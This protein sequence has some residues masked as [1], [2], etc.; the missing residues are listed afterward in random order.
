MMNMDAKEMLKAEARR[1]GFSHLGI[2]ALDPTPHASSY[3]GWLELGWHASM[4]YLSAPRAV[5]HRLNPQQ[6]FPPARSLIVITAAYPPPSTPNQAE[7]QPG[8][9][10]VA[11]YA[12]GVD[13]HTLLPPQLRRLV[14]WIQNE[15][16]P[17][18]QAAV[19]TDT[20]P[21]LERDYASRAGLG[22]IGKN[23]C[24]INPQAGS[25]LFLAEIFLSTP[26][27]PDDPFDQ[28]LCGT[29]RRCIEACPTGCI[30]EA[31]L[32]DARRCIS[33]LTIEN[34]G[35][36]P[37]ELR[38]LIGS[39]VFG[40]DICQQVC[41][42]NQKIK[43]APKTPL[44]QSDPA[45]S[46]LELAATLRLSPQEFNRRY[47]HTPLQRAKRRGLLR[48]A[49]VVAGN[50]RAEAALPVLINLLE[51]EFEPLVRAHAAWVLGQ[52]NNRA[53]RVALEK[54]L[55][56]ESDPTILAEI[57]SALDSH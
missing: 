56:T 29:C 33:Y 1:L 25:Y 13:Y 41:P 37:I 4:A 32:L 47:R 40:C 27:E 6:V 10:L 30:S 35:E 3:L 38:P 44:F 21:I 31:R 51:E 26:L 15:I 16:D 19:Y 28:D 45:L 20:G 55:K 34:K 42:W 43:T 11:A 12:R 39:H 54:A 52:F 7:S 57:H 36:I 49:A 23:T 17:R 8:Y 5:E 9:G 18:A 14:Q 46:E 2:S 24:L 50:Q 48:N 53:G 22:W